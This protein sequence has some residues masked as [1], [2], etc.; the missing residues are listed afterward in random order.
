MN[1]PRCT[2][3]VL[4]RGKVRGTEVEID[5]CPYCHG[6]WFDEGELTAVLGP[7]ATLTNG[8]PAHAKDGQLECPRCARGVLS[9]FCFPGTTV[10]VDGCRT[11]GGLWLDGGEG[12]ALRT[13]LFKPSPV[14]MTCPKCETR[15]PKAESCANCGVIVARYRPLSER[16]NATPPPPAPEE[17][18]VKGALLRFIDDCLSNLTNW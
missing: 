17:R 10:V 1:C 3:V 5:S 13:A 15:Q 12:K 9:W 4:Q 2:G 18:G 14:E 11:C 8:I 6:Y 16:L 7:R